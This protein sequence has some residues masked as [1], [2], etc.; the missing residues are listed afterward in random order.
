[1]YKTY[2]NQTQEQLA[3]TESEISYSVPKNEAIKA[4]FS[5]IKGTLLES[6]ALEDDIDD[7]SINQV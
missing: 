6:I 7:L 5:V 2:K 4:Y 3:T 1:V